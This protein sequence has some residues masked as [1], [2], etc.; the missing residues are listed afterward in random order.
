MEWLHPAPHLLT[1]AVHVSSVGE[2]DV[3]RQCES[4]RGLAVAS[5]VAGGGL[6]RSVAMTPIPMGHSPGMLPRDALVLGL[7]PVHSCKPSPP[8]HT[9]QIEALMMEMQNPDTGIK[10][11]MQTVTVANIPHAVTGKSFTGRRN[12]AE[13]A[14]QSKALCGPYGHTRLLLPGCYWSPCTPFDTYLLPLSNSHSCLISLLA[15]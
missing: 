12:W 2:S 4:W 1:L 15:L 6:G 11:Q 5:P 9:L 8:C 7:P 10:T 13:E 14:H 3:V